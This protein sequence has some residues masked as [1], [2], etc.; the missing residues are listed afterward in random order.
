MTTTDGRSERKHRRRDPCGTRS[1]FENGLACQV[2]H[3]RNRASDVDYA[4]REDRAFGQVAIA[5]GRL[6]VTMIFSCGFKGF[7]VT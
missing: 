4:D 3:E 1:I 6:E 5:N 7:N 2:V